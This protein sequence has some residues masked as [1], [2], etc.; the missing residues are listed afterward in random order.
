[1]VSCR[2]LYTNPEQSTLV[3]GPF[4][5]VI[6]RGSVTAAGIDRVREMG[7]VTLQGS[8]GGA[9]LFGI[10]EESAAMP[11]A[12]QRR[13]SAAVNDELASAGVVGFGAV[14][15]SQGFSGAIVRS[16]VT[17]L[18][19]IARNR[20]A[21]RAFPSVAHTCEWGAK[22]LR[23]ADL[24][25]RAHAV[26]IDRVRHEHAVRFSQPLSGLRAHDALRKGEER[27][28]THIGR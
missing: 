23:A 3:S 18:N 13:R 4:G 17:G 19:Q 2:T 15:G 7:L 28:S 25:W 8:P 21:F 14:L 1:M 6:W 11:D 9:V 22:L 16:V 12:D 24:D 27:R 5:V 10:I 20:Y 26:E